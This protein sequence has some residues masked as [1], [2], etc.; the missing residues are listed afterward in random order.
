[1]RFFAP[2]IG[3]N[4]D[5]V[6]GVAHATTAVYLAEQGLVGGEPDNA[7]AF[8]GEQGNYVERYGQ[9]HVE[10]VISNSGRTSEVR[11][12]GLAVTVIKG[13]LRIA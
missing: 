9:V 8:L 3:I 10:C 7:I 1:L 6:S 4:E 5:P 12:G 2:G 11:I 13:Q